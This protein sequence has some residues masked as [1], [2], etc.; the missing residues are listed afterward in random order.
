MNPTPAQK[1]LIL[2]VINVFETG[3]PDG[4][5]G[6]ITLLHDG[7]GGIRQVTYGR[8]QTTEYGNLRDLVIA[9]AATGGQYANDLRPYIVKIGREALVGD[10]DFL[11]LLKDAGRNDPIMRDTQDKFFDSH[12]YD[13]AIRWATEDGFNE[14]LSALVIYDSFIHSGTILKFLRQRFP[15]PVPSKGGNERTWIAQYVDTR[16]HWLATHSNTILRNTIYRTECFKRELAR[17]N[18][19]LSQIPIDANDTNVS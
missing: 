3:K 17:G 1:R 12:Y 7:P 14:A 19:D 10:G 11:Q 6:N 18:W 15:E 9:Y 16:H 4:D 5:Y 2:R 8:S 13:P